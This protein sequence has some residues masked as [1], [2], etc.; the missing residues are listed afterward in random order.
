MYILHILH[1]HPWERMAEAA[2]RKY[3]NPYNNNINSLDIIERRVTSGPA[4]VLQLFSHRMFCT[5]WNLP[6]IA[7]KVRLSCNM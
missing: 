5:L 7:L 3:P 6:A 4:G 1:S 2:F